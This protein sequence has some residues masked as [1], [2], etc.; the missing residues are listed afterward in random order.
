[1]ILPLRQW[2]GRRSRLI[3]GGQLS[4]GTIVHVLISRSMII[5]EVFMRATMMMFE[6]KMAAVAVMVV[7]VT[8]AVVIPVPSE[9]G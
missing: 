8:F 5:L 3:G 2:C 9:S 1:M 7:F 6:F 4:S